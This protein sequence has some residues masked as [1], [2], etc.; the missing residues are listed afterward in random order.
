MDN[1]VLKRPILSDPGTVERILGEIRAGVRPG[2]FI[3]IRELR[4]RLFDR[5]QLTKAELVNFVKV[6]GG[7][8]FEKYPRREHRG[9]RVDN[10][11]MKAPS[12]YS[13]ARSHG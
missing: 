13:G 11:L 12:G 3:T 2:E 10:Y 8:L 6:H 1:H 5:V 9:L 7:E 4:D